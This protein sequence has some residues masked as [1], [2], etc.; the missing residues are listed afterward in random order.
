MFCQDAYMNSVWLASNHC[1]FAKHLLQQAYGGS[2]YF[3]GK[4]PFMRPYWKVIV[5]A[6]FDG[7]CIARYFNKY[8][9]CAV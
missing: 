7:N 6:I 2:H 8:T 5:S 1:R 4:L 3:Q 9:L